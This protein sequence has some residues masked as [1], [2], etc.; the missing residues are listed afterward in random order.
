MPID[1]PWRPFDPARVDDLPAN[2]GVYELSDADGNIIYIGFAGARSRIGLRGNIADH[3]SD[4]EPNAGIR[5]RVSRFRLEV[6]T[7]YYARWVDLLTQH[8]SREG[9]I[10]VANLSADVPIPSIGRLSLPSGK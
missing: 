9:E 10:P 1:R 4:S 2:A 5:G 3:F 7:L 6:N 8:K